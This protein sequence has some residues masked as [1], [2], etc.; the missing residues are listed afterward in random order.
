MISASSETVA[1]NITMGIATF[2]TPEGQAV[3]EKAY[4]AIHEV[5]PNGDAWVKCIS[6]EKVPYIVALVKEVLRFW[7]VIPV[8]LPRTSIR[9]IPW[10]DSVIPAGTTF[11]MV[12][13][14]PK[15]YVCLYLLTILWVQNAWAADYDEDHFKEPMLFSPERFLGDSSDSVT[16]TPHFAYGAGSRMCIGTHLAN[17]ELYTAFVRLIT[18]F[19]VVAP[20]DPREAPVINCLACNS[21]PTSLT[22]NPRP[23]RVGLKARDPEALKRWIYEAEDRTSGM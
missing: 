19:K 12:S 11:F 20:R 1:A 18:A 5:Y 3:Q 13:L 17:R 4:N 22:T 23:F 2:S 16:G 7:T 10:A 21:N 14:L 6:E 9:D 15:S 8:C